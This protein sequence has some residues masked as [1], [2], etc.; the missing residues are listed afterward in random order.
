MIKLQKLSRGWLAIIDLK[1]TVAADYATLGTGCDSPHVVGEGDT[2]N[3]ATDAAVLSLGYL[4]L[5]EAA[6]ASEEPGT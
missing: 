4:L 2:P 1:G 3:E 5:N 6:D